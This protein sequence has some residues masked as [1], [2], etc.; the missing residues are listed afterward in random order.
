MAHFRSLSWSAALRDI[1]S[2]RIQLAPDERKTRGRQRAFA[3]LAAQRASA[4]ISACPLVNA[5]VYDSR[6]I[7]CT[8]VAA[9]K[10]R[11]AV[12][13][14]AWSVCISAALTGTWQVAK[15]ARL[16]TTL[17]EQG[18]FERAQHPVRRDNLLTV[19]AAEG[20]GRAIQGG[21]PS[22][23]QSPLPAYRPAQVPRPARAELSA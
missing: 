13:G 2:D 14:E 22:S 20:E 16:S 1:R 10:A 18:R 21:D 17:R 4:M 3:K 8:A 11:H 15:A 12:T 19:R 5:G 7:M 9:A 6:A 23:A